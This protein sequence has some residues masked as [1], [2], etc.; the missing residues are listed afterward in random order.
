MTTGDVKHPTTEAEYLAA[1]KEERKVARELEY[2]RTKDEQ[3]PPRA[4]SGG[5]AY[6]RS[7][8]SERRWRQRQREREQEQEA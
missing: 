5:P 8:R 6:E 3:A 1:W 4:A 2:L 7:P